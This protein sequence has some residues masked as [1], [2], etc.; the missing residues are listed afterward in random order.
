M[1][2]RI[3][4]QSFEWVRPTPPPSPLRSIRRKM[5]FVSGS[6]REGE[7]VGFCVRCSGFGNRNWKCIRMN[8][9]HCQGLWRSVVPHS[10]YGTSGVCF[11]VSGQNCFGIGLNLDI[12]TV[13]AIGKPKGL[14]KWGRK[15]V[16]GGQR[17]FNLERCCIQS[18]N[19]F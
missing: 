5:R 2:W 18:R 13:A 16:V 11:V 10:H 17:A 6:G 3:K 12:L 9:G 1:P 7:S 4:F 14:L 15:S 8:L 19:L